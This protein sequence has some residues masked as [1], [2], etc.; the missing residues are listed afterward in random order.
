[1][2]TYVSFANG[3]DK[4]K[5]EKAGRLEM[6]FDVP[7]QEAIDYFK[8]KKI[9]TKKEFDKL[10]NE[11][12]GGS[13][14]V[15]GVYKKDV[16]TALHKEI[17]DALESGQSQKQTIKNFKEILEGAGHK[18]LGDFHLETVFRANMQTAYGVGRRRLMEDSA[19][20]L[21]FW[22]YSAVNDNRTRPMHRA[23]DGLVYPANHEFWDEH[24]PPWGFNCRCSVIALLDYPDDYNHAKPNDD[25][26]IAYDDDGLPA[27]AEYL[28]QG[29]DL[30]ATNFVGVPRA[31]NLEEV[32]KQN[33]IRA[34]TI[35]RERDTYQTPKNIVEKAKEIRNEKKEN[36]HLFDAKG[37]HLFSAIGDEN[38]FR[39]QLPKEIIPKAIGGIDVH[40]HPPQ[41][42]RMFESFSQIDF[43]D[44]M[45]WKVTEKL[46]ATKIFLYSLRPPKTGWD[47][48][49]K[50]NV[51]ERFEKILAEISKEYF[52]RYRSGEMTLGAIEDEI[53]HSAWKKVA[54]EYGLRYKRKRI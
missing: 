7:P 13:F 27:K 1:M 14:Y 53:R 47:G 39:V 10:S 11:A 4:K 3:D 21:P 30:K 35:K 48:L 28:N 20:L 8:R 24:Y 2:Q 40:N 51:L 19:D 34:E 22:Q 12:K 18:E 41:G 42:D 50:K 25:T 54:K 33:A 9:V 17:S 29:V 44:A 26:T 49:V 52:E 16:L 15:S 46:V 6:N 23:L 43:A 5:L 36:Y 31:A 45:D 32:L 38:G 37:N